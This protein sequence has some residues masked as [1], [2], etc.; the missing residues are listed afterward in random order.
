MRAKIQKS[1]QFLLDYILLL[2]LILYL[3]EGFKILIDTNSNLKLN[4]T[5]IL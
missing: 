1:T 4:F 2:C 5:N 3:S